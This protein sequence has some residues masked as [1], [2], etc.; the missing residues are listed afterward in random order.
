MTATT[1]NRVSDETKFFIGIDVHKKKWVVTIRALG[2]FLQ[3]FSMNPS[4][5]ELEK[6]LRRKYPKGK[7][8]SVYEAGF[9]GFWIHRKLISLGIESRVTN[10]ADVPTTNKEKVNKRDKVDSKKL[11]RELEKG[12]LTAI[13][14]PE[15]EHQQLRSLCRL[16][17]RYSQQ[18]TRIK[19]PHKKLL[20]LL[21]YFSY[22]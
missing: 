8:Y 21:W 13:Y 9:C 1:S 2:M 7:Y 20:I 5:Q 17:H 3:T 11:A 6:H 4:P 15:I 18:I 14:V 12:D 16:R 19:K 10:A 22:R